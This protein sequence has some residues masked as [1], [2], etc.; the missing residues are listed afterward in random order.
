M[1]LKTITLE[2]NKLKDT[3]YNRLDPKYFFVENLFSRI[4]KES[5]HPVKLLNELDVVI[6][7]GSYI[8]TYVNKC[9][10]IPYLRVG[11]IKPFCISEQEEGIVYVDKNVSPKMIT[12]RNDIVLGRTQAT[13]HKLGVSSIIDETSEGS[14]ISQHLSKI[15]I[16][17]TGKISPY[18]LIAYFNSKFI[19]AQMALASHGDTRVELTLSQLRS[20]KVFVP[21]EKIEASIEEKVKTIVS[22]NTQANNLIKEAQ[23]IIYSKL[24]INFP[25]M[26]LVKFFSVSSS[27]LNQG[28]W[29]PIYSLPVYAETLNSIRERVKTIFLKD[30]V[31]VKKGNEVGSENY[32]EDLDR[33]DDHVP[34]IRTSDLI[35]YEVDQFPD[36]FIAED[37]YLSLKQDIKPFD[38]LYNNDG[39]IGVVA[40][41]TPEDKFILQSHIQRIRLNKDAKEKYGLTQEYLFLMLSIKEIGKYQAERYTVIQSTIPTISNHILDFEIP[42]FDSEI[43][44][45]V[46]DMVKKAFALKQKRKV[47]VNT[48][49]EEIDQ[50]FEF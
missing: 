5:H 18:Y 28:M 38:I 46:T 11:N 39:K 16:R 19:K 30:L 24:N 31:T 48:V 2:Y 33:S 25:K 47:L 13:I 42:L 1:S 8:D 36:Y 17:K 32:T 29:T 44:R 14:A 3:D 7:S 34:F 49:R 10:G 41:V 27:I 15:R 50:W 45:R 6:D 43:I 20:V 37:I 4:S 22:Y 23:K 12:E 26:N 35:N 9:E 21:D 40:M